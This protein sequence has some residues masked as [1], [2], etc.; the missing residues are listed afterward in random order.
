[1]VLAVAAFKKMKPEPDEMW[2]ALGTGA[3]FRYVAVHQVVSM[4]NPGTW[5]TVP[6]FHEFT[7]CD[8]LAFGGRGKKTAWN[9][10][11]VLPEVVEA[12]EELKQMPDNLSHLSVSRLERSV[13]LMHHNNTSSV[14][15]QKEARKQLFTHPPTQCL[16]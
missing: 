7:G 11:K 13:V 3:S 15:E 14:M 9:T 12:F 16:R 2:I 10:W 4:L 8:T 5:A 1:M 6:F